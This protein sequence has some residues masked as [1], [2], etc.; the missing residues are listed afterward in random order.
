MK[1][2]NKK[3]SFKIPLVIYPFDVF[4]SFNHNDKELYELIKRNGSKEDLEPCFGL[5]DTSLGRAVLL[6]SNATIL[7]IFGKRCNESELMG[8][9]A[10]EVFH[11][12]SY[13]MMRVGIPLEVMVSD[14]AYAYLT[15]YLVEQIFKALC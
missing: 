14:E 11:V 9:I 3:F 2:K 5:P 7:R 4:V 10:H 1:N 15:G 13:I 12:V 6:P 8:V